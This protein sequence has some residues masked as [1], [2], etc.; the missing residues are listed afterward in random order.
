MIITYHPKIDIERGWNIFI[1]SNL[2]RKSVCDSQ[3]CVNAKGREFI[4]NQEYK[5]RIR[6]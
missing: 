3:F 2:L 1:E 4:I 6:K 5:R